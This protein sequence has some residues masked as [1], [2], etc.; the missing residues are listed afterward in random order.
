MNEE[1]S[2]EIEIEQQGLKCDAAGCDYTYVF[3]KV[4]TYE[5][6][7]NAPC[8]KCGANL[9]TQE[10]YDTMMSFLDLV[11]STNS[12]NFVAPVFPDEIQALVDQLSDPDKKAKLKME[13]V[14]G[15]PVMTS[16][17]PEVQGIIDAL[18]KFQKELIAKTDNLEAE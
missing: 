10:D 16:D 14:D 1:K 7:L 15:L 2:V 12:P 9:L 13:F 11:E 8:P 4:D 5:K 18:D 6:Y 17:D 3:N